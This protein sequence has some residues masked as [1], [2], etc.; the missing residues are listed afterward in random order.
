MP[1]SMAELRHQMPGVTLVPHAVVSDRVR[2][3]DWWTSPASTRLLFSEY[4]KYILAVVRTRV[5]N[6]LA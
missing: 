4:L 1:R 6:A 2:V 5:A 3:E